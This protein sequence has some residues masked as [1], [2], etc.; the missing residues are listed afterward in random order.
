MLFH[1]IGNMLPVKD[2]GL[3]NRTALDVGTRVTVYWS[4]DDQ[5]YKGTVA[6]RR[7]NGFEHLIDYDD[8]DK[9]WMD[10]RNT[11]WRASTKPD[12]FIMKE[13]AS[14]ASKKARIEKL[15]VGSRI[16]VWWPREKE[17]YS[18]TISEIGVDEH[19]KTTHHVQ[20]DD[21]DS[22]WE[23]LV[24][25]KFK[26]VQAKADRV[27][28]GSR[29]S[30]LDETDRKYYVGTVTKIRPS[31]AKPHR[32]AYDEDGRQR[33]WIN[34]STR[35][36]IDID[37]A[38]AAAKPSN[39]PVNA[40]TLKKR[41]P[42]FLNSERP[43][44]RKKKTVVKLEEDTGN[45]LCRETCY[46]CQEVARRPRATS[47]QHIFCKRCIEEHCSSQTNRICPICSF[48]LT[49]K[50]AR[51]DPESPSFK[52]VE[53]LE[54]T[55]AE[56]RYAF[57]SASAASR[58]MKG[59]PLHIIEA[60]QSKRRDDRE[61]RGFYWRFKGCK[62]R[63]LRAGEGVKEGLPVEQVSLETGQIIAT[64]PSAR[65][66]AE[67]TGVDRCALRRVLKRKGKANA[68]GFFWRF[69][70]DTHGPWPDPEP[71]NLNPLEKLDFETGD[72]L[73]SF[74]SLAEAKRAMNMRPNSACI[75]EV[76]DG[77]G[78]ASAKGFFWRWKDSKALPDHMM[79]V[80]K[81][82]QIRKK[83][84]KVVKE[85]RSSLEAQAYFGY[86]FCWSTVCHY[87]REKGYY[88]GYYWSYRMITKQKSATEA[89]VGKRLR[90]LL[91][92][93][94]NEEW[95]EGKVSAFDPG[96][97]LH[98]ITLDRGTIERLNLDDIPYEWK[99]D[100]GQKPVEKLDLK[101]GEVLAVFPSISDAASN[102][103]ARTGAAGRPS[104][105][106]AVCAG[107]SRSAFGFFWRYKGS[108]ILPPKPKLQRRVEQL[109]LQ[110]GRV[111]ATFNTIAAAGKA[112]GITTPG[113][114]YCC[115][116][117]NGSKSAGGFGWRFN[118][119]MEGEEEA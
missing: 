5:W 1:R 3:V 115:N 59:L 6:K 55:T 97:G 32:I 17:Y 54:M 108:T 42:E 61:Y 83:N 73:E 34:L 68:R 57:S 117:R 28:L 67:K 30:V 47:C 27:K 43:A 89:V 36:F 52:A 72:Y 63:I 48:H 76:C 113:I 74:T 98:E 4:D 50:L 41:K 31:R 105:I 96:T 112:V 101:T 92:A 8:G 12:R 71:T 38:G 119:Q 21:G 35:P 10:V 90:L 78:R 19:G 25:K 37:A 84:G 26:N 11:R 99:N 51:F 118:T 70:G 49:S 23:D 14:L 16:S 22:D 87:C 65:K 104:G 107:R 91:P 15:N 39:G 80:Q 79:G 88:R 116:G 29:V 75:R 56:V 66:A 95:L 45:P 58:E 44:K 69:E 18:G 111:I 62:D 40:H 7:T 46:L 103:A 64:F 94:D 109:C 93:D 33:E 114:S 82:V 53:A 85:F 9:D 100:Q 24:Y 60:C 110:S 81:I 106:I 102:T 2:D 20:Y 13:P 86:Q 77:K